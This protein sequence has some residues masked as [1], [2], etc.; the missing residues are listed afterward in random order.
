MFSA[1]RET[2]M[3]KM[4]V[5][6]GTN[7]DGKWVAILAV[8]EPTET[9]TV[10]S[11]TQGRGWRKIVRGSTN[12]RGKVRREFSVGR[13]HE[14]LARYLGPLDF[15]RERRSQTFIYGYGAVR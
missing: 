4:S 1:H 6:L 3:T 11:A 9:T 15:N 12:V 5:R 8:A 14:L 2:Q 7:P 13:C 10:I